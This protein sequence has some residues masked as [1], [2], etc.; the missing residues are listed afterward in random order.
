MKI[1]SDSLVKVSIGIN[2]GW[3]II[4]HGH[5]GR[6]V[7]C[8][9]K[10]LEGE[11]EGDNGGMFRG[12]CF[13]EGGGGLEGREEGSM[14]KVGLQLVSVVSSYRQGNLQCEII[15]LVGKI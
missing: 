11:G 12:E 4:C 2:G 3:L 8:L 10:G 7:E 5:Q 13:K 15:F 6:P 9:G 1:Q 14:L